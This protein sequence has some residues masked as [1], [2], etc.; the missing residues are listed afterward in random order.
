[1]EAAT[2][3]AAF[4]RLDR[5]MPQIARGICGRCDTVDNILTKSEPKAKPR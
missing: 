2:A 3:D 1:M 5:R 4:V